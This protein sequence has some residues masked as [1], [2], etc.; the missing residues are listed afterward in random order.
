MLTLKKV[1]AEE[2]NDF[3]GSVLRSVCHF[4]I[5]ADGIYDLNSSC[6]IL[7]TTINTTETTPALVGVHNCFLGNR[8]Q[9]LVKNCRFSTTRAGI[10][11]EMTHNNFRNVNLEKFTRSTP[12]N[13]SEALFD[14]VQVEDVFSNHYSCFRDLHRV[15]ETASVENRPELRIPLREL[16]PG[17]GS[18]PQYPSFKLGKATVR[19][20]FQAG[21][22]MLEETRRY[23]D[24]TDAAKTLACDNI[25]AADVGERKVVVITPTTFKADKEIPLWVGQKLN[26]QR[27]I[28]AQVG[29][30][31]VLI[32]GIARN[33][34]TN[35]VTLTFSQSIATTAL[36]ISAITIIEVVV[37]SLAYKIEQP[38]L[39]LYQVKPTPSQM[40][41]ARKKLSNASIPY[42]TWSLEQDNLAATAEFNRQ[43]YLEPNCSN[44]VMFFQGGQDDMDSLSN[45]LGSFRCALN[46]IDI[47][48][49]DVDC[50]PSSPLYLDRAM[51]TIT[52]CGLPLRSLKNPPKCVLNP[53]PRVEQSQQYSV[54]LKKSAAGDITASNIH[55][56]KQLNRVIKISKNQVQVR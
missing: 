29:V 55:L 40:E 14:G 28:N 27:T 26:V 18:M 1:S 46:Q 2:S 37:D 15:G 56:Y 45:N 13:R 38:K 48:N 33:A 9:V 30:V 3:D 49:T 24:H 51:W 31:D 36:E 19:V 16:F 52:N 22:E 34:E 17:I 47:T 53:V 21:S 41:S 8:A 43:Y 7:P 10:L 32:A 42:R 39:L 54:Q 50:N 44:A 35:K 23:T 4:P 6:L 5:E 12:Q 20:E 25:A 11:E